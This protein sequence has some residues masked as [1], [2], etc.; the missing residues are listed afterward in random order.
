MLYLLLWLTPLALIFLAIWF[1]PVDRL[2]GAEVM[3]F[4]PSPEFKMP[5]AMGIDYLPEKPCST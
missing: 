5:E 4:E 3:D 1:S 2:G